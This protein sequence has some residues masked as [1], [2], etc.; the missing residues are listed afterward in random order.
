[1]S[2]SMIPCADLTRIQ[3]EMVRKKA[4]LLWNYLI[5]N[6]Q[7]VHVLQVTLNKANV[8]NLKCELRMYQSVTRCDNSFENDDKYSRRVYIQVG[9]VPTL[10]YQRQH[11]LHMIGCCLICFAMIGCSRLEGKIHA[12]ACPPVYSPW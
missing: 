6:F 12:L 3:L 4:N 10:P 7:K 5:S 9:K 2:W 1:M 11:L 8:E